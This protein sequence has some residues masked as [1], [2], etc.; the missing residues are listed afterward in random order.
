MSDKP[1]TTK[2]PVFVQGLYEPTQDEVTVETL[3]VTGAIRPSCARAICATVVIPGRATRPSAARLGRGHRH[4]YAQS[5]PRSEDGLH[6]VVKWNAKTG[7]H[8]LH[9]LQ[10][11]QIGSEPWFVPAV[12]GTAEDDGRALVLVGDRSA[13]DAMLL[14]LDAS[15]FAEPLVAT[16]KLPGWI[17]ADVHGSWIADSD[18]HANGASSHG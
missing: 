16:V 18:F 17:P 8:L 13:N 6:A 7:P 2:P 11:G 12:G 3:E 4:T 15:D 9:T 14:I 1:E 10:P 5:R